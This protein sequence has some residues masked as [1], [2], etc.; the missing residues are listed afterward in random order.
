MFQ[1]LVRLFNPAFRQIRVPVAPIR[2]TARE[3]GLHLV[4]RLKGSEK[5]PPPGAALLASCV[6]RYCGMHGLAWGPLVFWPKNQDRFAA[7]YC[8]VP[9]KLFTPPPVK[10][11]NNSA[12][13][14][15]S[16]L[17]VSE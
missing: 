14:P 6:S 8:L 12:Q 15:P 4:R 3:Q 5:A 17:P 1:F 13:L 11:P 10:L 7:P 9:P 2:W 16:L